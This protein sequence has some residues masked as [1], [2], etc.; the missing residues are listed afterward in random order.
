MNRS[1]KGMRVVCGL[2]LLVNL[3]LFF[4]PVTQIERKNAAGKSELNYSQFD[5]VREMTKGELPHDEYL[6]VDAFE[7]ICYVVTIVFMVI[8]FVCSVAGGICGLAGG[9]RQ[10]VTG[11][12]SL[13]VLGC[14]LGQYFMLE[15]MWPD[16]TADL[17]C[18][19]GFGSMLT[20]A[21]S[22]CATLFGI[23]SFVFMPRRKKPNEN[24]IPQVQEIR[25]EQN[26]AM[27]HMVDAV[28][29]SGEENLNMNTA[30]SAALP[31]YVPQGEPR[32]VLVGLTGM[33]AGAEIAFTDRMM[34][35]LGRLPDNDLVFEN[36]QHISRRHCEITW[37]AVEKIFRIKDFSSSGSYINGSEDCIPQNI[38]TPLP[39]GT[40]LDIGDANN[41]FRLE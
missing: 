23:L 26:R 7:G 15:Q 5:Y 37:Y 28:S 8:P 35:R 29:G 11:I 30:A 24:K 33:Y 25:T 1:A 22:G 9:P 41:R 6:E 34:I 31:P 3:A 18:Q 21:V 4:L 40:V 14:Y 16:V 19:R 38:D 32:G 27:Y 2:L 20:L 10:L 39:P 12:G 17:S 36:E 13:L